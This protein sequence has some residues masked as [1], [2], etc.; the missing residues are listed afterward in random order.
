[1][2]RIMDQKVIQQ[3]LGKQIKIYTFI[4]GKLDIFL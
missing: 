2:S 3:D 4:S 1:M